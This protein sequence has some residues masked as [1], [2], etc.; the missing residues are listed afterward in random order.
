MKRYCL[1]LL[2]SLNGLSMGAHAQ[3]L[4]SSDLPIVLINTDGRTIVN[5]PKVAATLHII[6]NGSGKGNTPTDRPALSSTIG[7]EIRGASSQALFPKK[8]YGFELRDSLGISSINASVLGMPAESDWVL[9]A[10]Y[11]DKTLIRETLTYDLNRAMSPYYTPRYRYCEV[12]L[13]GSYAG[14]YILFEKIKRNKNRVNIT[15][16]KKTDIAGDALTGGYIFKIDKTEGSLS[17]SWDSPYRGTRGQAIPIQIDRPKPEDLAEEQFQYVRKYVTD[18]EKALSGAAFEDSLTGY[19]NYINDDSFVDYML[20]T[21]VCKNVDGY[22]LSTFFYKD[23]DSKGVAGKI[24]IGPIWDYNLAYGNAD[25][26]SANTFLGWAFDFPRIC[27]TDGFQTPFWWDRLLTDRAFAGK[28]RVKYL[29]LRQTVLKTERIQAHIDSVANVLTEARIRNFQR[30]PVLGLYVWPNSYVGKTYQDEVTYLKA[31]IKNRL[32][33]M[34]TAVLP[35]GAPVLASEPIDSFELV[36]SPNPSTGD[37]AV[38]YQ[39]TQGANLHLNIT[40]AT[41]RLLQSLALPGQPAGKHQ[42]I[43]P[44]LPVTPGIY[45][46]LLKTETTS[47]SRKLIRQ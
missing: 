42:R 37:V 19:R 32:E 13:N 40:D 28:V 10:T 8:S 1:W 5:E 23:R 20:M 31:W 47:V 25:Y 21:E 39:L 17:R 15:S 4:L 26:C 36:V 29:A 12:I 11:N 22:R 24:T 33:W 45:Y 9:N 14:I 41:G 2:L 16:I 35:F 46:I 38:R 44:N 3:V 27:P 43:I 34:D 18:F 7:I 30:W 6:D